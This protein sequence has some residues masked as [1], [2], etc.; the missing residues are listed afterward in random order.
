MFGPPEMTE[1]QLAYYEDV[2]RQTSESEAFAN[3]RDMIGQQ[4]LT[5]AIAVSEIPEVK[6]SME[7]DGDASEIQPFIE[8]IRIQS[9]AEFIVVGDRNEIRYTHPDP[10]K[11]GQNM[12]GGDNEQKF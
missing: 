9:G 12:V 4:A 3:I 1:E 2:F 7:I 8:R 5:T 11:V 10:S 6:R